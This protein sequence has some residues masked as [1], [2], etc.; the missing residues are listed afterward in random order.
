MNTLFPAN[1]FNKKRSAGN[2]VFFYII[3]DCWHDVFC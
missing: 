2:E 1:T 3:S